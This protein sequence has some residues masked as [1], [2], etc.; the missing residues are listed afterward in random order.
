M[1]E[2]KTPNKLLQFKEINMGELTSIF[3]SLKKS[4]SASE[5]KISTK[6]LQIIQDTIKYL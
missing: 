1:R 6:M 4:H 3:T 2:I 5:D